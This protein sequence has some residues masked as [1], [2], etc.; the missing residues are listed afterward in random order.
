MTKEE[1]AKFIEDKKNKKKE[2]KEKMKIALVEG[3]PIFIDLVF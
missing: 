1:V 3:Q 2:A